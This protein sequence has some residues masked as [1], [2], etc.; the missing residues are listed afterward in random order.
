[1]CRRFGSRSP[2]GWLTWLPRRGT[3]G[4]T[5]SRSR[6]VPEVR[7][8]VA[9]EYFTAQH[10]RP[11][12]DAREVAATIARHSRQRTTAVAGYDLTFSPVKCIS[13]L[14]AVAP[15]DVAAQVEAAHHDAVDDALAFLEAHALY[16]R[17]G[18]RGVRQVD[19]T[20]MV[21]AAFTH[22]DS[23]AGDPDLHTHVAVANKVQTTSG[24]WL[25]IDGRVLFKAN[26][27][28]SET[29]NTAIEKHL[30]ARLGVVFA[31]RP[32]TDRGKRPIREIVGV[33][34]ALN[35]RWST[36]RASIQVRRG[37]LA[38]TFQ[39]DHGRPPTVVESIQLAQQATL[40]TREAKHEPRT[41]AEQRSTW[42]REAENVLGGPAGLTAMV[43]AALSP[44]IRNQAS[45]VDAAWVRD[46]AHTVLAA[47]EGSRSTWQVWHVR[48]EAQRRVR[49]MDL[50]PERVEA[51]VDLVVDEVLTACSIRVTQ[52]SDDLVEPAAL[53]RQDGCSVY[54]VAGSTLYTSAA[55]LAAEQRL[56][57]AAGRYDGH[58][59]SADSVGVALLEQAANGVTL[60]AGQA[61]LVTGM[62]TS[63][64]RLQLAIAPAGA[65]KTTT[66]RALTAAWTADGGTVLGLAPSAAAAAV[67]REQTGAFTD[68]LAKLTW[69]LQQQDLP[70]WARDIGPATLVVVDEAGMADTLSLAA[71]VDFVIARGASVRLVGDDQQLAA[72][73]AGGVLRD[74]TATHGALRLSELMRFTDPAEAA[75][76]LALRDGHSEALG[77]Y[78]DRGRVH[79][80]DPATTTEQVFTAWAQDRDHGLDSIMLAPTRELVAELNHRAQTH[81][82]THLGTGAG[83]GPGVA[84]ADGNTAHVGD[85]VIT[86]TNDRRLRT[87]ATDWVKNGDRWTVQE[88]N[89]AGALRVRHTRTGRTLTLPAGYVAASVELGYASTVHGAQGVSVDTMHGLA[90]GAESRQQLYTMLTRGRLTNHVHVQVVGDGD[91]HTV[92]RPENL[93]PDTAT[94]LLERVLARDDSPVSATTLLREQDRP[95]HPPG[96]RGRPVRR[97][98][99]RRRRTPPRPARPRGSGRRRRPHR[100]RPHPGPGMAHPARPPDPAR[101]PRDDPLACLTAA[102]AGR[103]L[104]TAGDRA[105]VL[106]WRLEDPNPATT[107]TA[108]AGAG[109]LPW[110]PAL[111]DALL[112]DK[113][114]G[115][116]LTA[117]AQLVTDLA[118]QVRDCTRTDPTPGWVR[119]SHARPDPA[120]LADVAV[121]RAA[122][123]VNDSDRRP[124]GPRQPVKA[125]AL[126]QRQL[127][128]RLTGDRSPAL[129]EW[130]APAP[131]GRTRRARR[132][133]HPR[134]GRTAR[135]RLPRPASTPTT[136]CAPRPPKPTCPMATPPP[137]CGGG[138]AAT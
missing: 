53:R 34:P 44:G 85:L 116:Y 41:L 10:G 24:K 13:T 101:R 96:R 107:I 86:R 8:Q 129:A 81:R 33:D 29:Y 23:R 88:A 97:R 82:S 22:R 132:R 128:A 98:P 16:S 25:S 84:L 54:E 35:Q 104:D 122:T 73:G 64:A 74:I 115:T 93:H 57:D 38:Q 11:P 43:A 52:P 66:M 70:G 6:S 111:P 131:P 37:Q 110:L 137:R 9:V 95:R 136:S 83:S 75:A 69:S 77:F 76:S 87:S 26:V 58:T 21:A 123:G 65:G 118:A 134:P 100:R 89:T 27:A 4:T 91:P 30:H 19:V 99:A 71:V 112:T 80:G 15:R 36:R 126:H 113:T 119:H 7:T 47:L 5:R 55:I 127:Q 50:A 32:G 45:G 20:G 102:A 63:G 48:A 31:Q 135:R 18:A 68:T 117:R 138:S 133:V 109:P 56:V 62:A 60:N 92:I 114:W 103:E 90:T 130:G 3:R 12:A 49:P 39:A 72:I 42:R 61:A 1:M 46:T 67:L 106:D 40:E 121:W 105:A 108:A 51:V 59:A 17:E 120:L 124:T 2:P 28:A 14:W 94:D 125:F 78:L 79:V